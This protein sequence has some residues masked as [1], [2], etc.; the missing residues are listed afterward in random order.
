MLDTIKMKFFLK[1]RE[2]EQERQETM[3]NL[4]FHKWM[5]ELNVSQS[6]EDK[7][8]KINARELQMHYDTKK[9][10]NLQFNH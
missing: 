7:T 4:E 9:Y 3:S 8:S 10:S 2:L 6:Y 5:K 1:M